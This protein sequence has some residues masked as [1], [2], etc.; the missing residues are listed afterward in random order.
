[1]PFIHWFN[2]VE[3]DTAEDPSVVVGHVDVTRRMV[4]NPPFKKCIRHGEPGPFVSLEV[5]PRGILFCGVPIARQ[6]RFAQSS[7]IELFWG[8]VHVD[9]VAQNTSAG[10]LR[11]RIQLRSGFEGAATKS[12]I[13][14]K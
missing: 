5:C 11:L 14:P 8:V 13:K 9:L 1:M 7:A 4:P 3:P 12:N 6:H 10:Q 2:W